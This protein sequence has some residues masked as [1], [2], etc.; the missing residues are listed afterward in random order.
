MW[1]EGPTDILLMTN[2]P[3]SVDNIWEHPGRVRLLMFLGS[4]GRV[5][6]FD[7]RGLGGSDP[8]AL[9]EVGD[10]ATWA[11]DA[12][13]VLDELNIGPV[14]VIAEGYA[15]HV[16]VELAQ[17]H[18][19]RITRLAILNG[20]AR[21]RADADYGM[22]HGE[23]FVTS[24]LSDVDAAWGTG[25]VTAAVLPTL[26]K[27]APDPGFVARSERLGATR[28]SARAMARRQFT[29]DVR[30]LLA[31]VRIPAMVVYTGDSLLVRQEHC[32]YVADHIP[33]AELVIAPSR[34]FYW[35]EAGFDAFAEFISGSRDSAAPREIAAVLFT[36][37]VES[38]SKAA[39][40]GDMRWAQV[41][42]GLDGFVGVEA[43][44]SGGR[45]VKQTGD[46]HVVVFANP[47]NA[48]SAALRVLDAA[49]TF[50]IQMR[51]GIHM[52]AV[53]SRRGGDI[54]GI[55]VHV[56]QRVAAAAHPG[57]L[58]VS[59]TV[60]DLLGGSSAVVFNDRGERELKGVPGMWRLYSATT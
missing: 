17:H 43:V 8:V 16:G 22:G 48:V 41:L 24:A 6:R 57:E 14:V 1:G 20:Y 2:W 25:Q 44:R 42:E 36:D 39:S 13:R 5:V 53:E 19:E 40:L 9:D 32:A 4:I 59:Q 30:P 10:V 26:A 18:T 56:A 37:I 47:T 50:E 60:A 12:V 45:V 54:A 21:L 28:A 31:A 49:P 7:P 15:S 55:A 29:S 23:E 33:D 52:G 51:A 46:G 58:L 35:G 38:T 3:T 34:S 27:G 11:E